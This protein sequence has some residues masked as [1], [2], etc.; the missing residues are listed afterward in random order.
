MGETASLILGDA[1][2][3]RTIKRL[4]FEI[5]ER[6]RGL[7]NVVIVG[8]QHRGLAVA[9]HL[10][11]VLSE[12]AGRPLPVHPLDVTAYRDDRDTSSAPQ[13]PTFRVEAADVVLVDDVLYTGR[14]VRA[15]LD[16]LIQA[17][18]PSSIQL[19]VLVDRGHREYP[20][21]PDYVGRVI[22]TAYREHVTVSLES[23]MGIFVT[24]A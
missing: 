17:G 12:I 8:I 2:I 1:Q 14:T 9:Q 4:A 23:P 15:A 16:A 5:V 22:E 11:D 10:S 7:D 19:A 18:R 21:R 13:P 20:I 3:R 24:D 6:N